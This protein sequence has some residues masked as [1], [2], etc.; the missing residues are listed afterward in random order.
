VIRPLRALALLLALPLVLGAGPARADDPAPPG[1][2]Q[3]AL[4]TFAGGCFWCMQPP[5]ETLPGVLETTV[6]YTGGTLP[7]PTHEQV[8]AGGTGHAESVEIVYDPQKISYEK[9]LDVFWHNIDPVTRDAQFCD[10]GHQYRTAIF[11]HDDTQRQLA[12]ASKRALEASGRLPGPIVTEIVPAGEFWPAEEY[13]QDYHAKNPVRYKYYRWN[14]G[15]D[16]RL[17]ALWGADAPEKSS[18][19]ESSKSK[20]GWDPM[21]WKKPDASELKQKL[22]PLQYDVT[23]KEATER[24]FAN[25]Y[26]D[27]HEPGIYVDVVSGE[28]LFSSLD[29]FDSGT[30]WPSFTRPLETEN[31]TEHSDTKL[32]MRRTEVRSAHGDSHLG[33]VFEDGPAPT[34]MR[35]CINSAS[36]RFIPVDQLEAEGYGE[37]LKLFE[38]SGAET[39]AKAK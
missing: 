7:H 13:H 18:T 20:K 16:Q 24:P 8:S 5:F 37:Y 38:K 1:E 14:C 27:N 6:G 12:E 23:Q 10:H 11:Y 15:R 2:G 32:F 17:E 39:Q 30:G 34:G 33:H 29:K 19:K 26:W 4:A 21:A 25:A 9:L 31:V 36:L 22:T 28:P 3:R 35:Y